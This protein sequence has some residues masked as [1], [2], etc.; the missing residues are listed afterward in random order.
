MTLATLATFYRPA[1]IAVTGAYPTLA[2]ALFAWARASASAVGAPWPSM[3]V[4]ALEDRVGDLDITEPSGAAEHLVCDA[5]TAADDAAAD[6]ADGWTVPDTA[7]LVAAV[8]ARR[9]CGTEDVTWG[10]GESR[11]RLHMGGCGEWYVT[12]SGPVGSAAASRAESIGWPDEQV[13]ILRSGVIPAVVAR[14]FGGGPVDPGY[15]TP[16][17]DDEACEA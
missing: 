6:A 13:A 7:A 5:I 17:G 16:Y 1:V 9:F 3:L 12:I 2:V 10:T 8:E 4:S 11:V 14:S 15:R